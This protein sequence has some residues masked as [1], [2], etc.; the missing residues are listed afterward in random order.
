MNEA[1]LFG[2]RF[3]A[4]LVALLF[5]LAACGGETGTTGS[6]D[7]IANGQATFAAYCASCHGPGGRGDGPVAEALTTPPADLTRLRAKYDG[8]FPADSVYA[9]IDGRQDVVAHGTREMPVWGN[10]WSE[11]HGEPVPLADSDLRVR[12]LVEYLR[13]LQEEPGEAS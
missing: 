10:V 4:A 13:T 5:T 7:P 11:E 12:E 6:A 2:S 1:T 8:A 9:S 3:A